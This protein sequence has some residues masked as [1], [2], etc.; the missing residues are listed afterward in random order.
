MYDLDK[1]EEKS[2][3]IKDTISLI[4]SVSYILE[5]AKY[6]ISKEWD[7]LVTERLKLER[8]KEEFNKLRQGDKYDRN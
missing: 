1:I 7:D 3:S 6:R 4:T 5:R 2:H 8:E